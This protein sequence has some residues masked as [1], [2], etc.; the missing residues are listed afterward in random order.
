MDFYNQDF[1]KALDQLVKESEIII[2]R[3]HNQAQYLKGIL[4]ER[5]PNSL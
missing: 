4:I 1:W 3:F 2:Y 5:D